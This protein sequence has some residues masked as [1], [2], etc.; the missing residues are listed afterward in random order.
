MSL[1]HA[2]YGKSIV[3]VFRIVRSEA[4][5]RAHDIVEYDV[6]VH[7]EGDLDTSYTQ[8]DNSIVVTTD[9]V[10]NI[11]YHL[12]KISPHILNP[13]RFGLQIGSFFLT[14]YSHIHL[15]HIVIERL[16]WSRIVFDVD[17]KPTP[18]KHSFLRDGE[19]K[20]ITTVDVSRTKTAASYSATVKS[21]LKDLL[22][23]KSTGSSFSNYIYDEY[24]LLKPVTERV[25]ST[26]VEVEYTYPVVEITDKFGSTPEEGVGKDGVWLSE[27]T[28]KAVRDI[29][30][31]VFA[32]DDSASVQATLYKMATRVVA[33]NPPV[34][35][36]SYA[37]PNK[38]YIPVD[39]SYLGIDNLTPE[40]AEVF[41]PV[42]APS[43]FISAT[44]AR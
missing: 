43:G 4:D 39:L 32:T 8:A 42:S 14:K 22:V 34:Q 6:A 2:R 26:S 13:E 31:E 30:L 16:K 41:A 23:L 1:V 21:S 36:I 37:L 7:L 19:E 20:T 27:A 29:T 40:K 28:T 44:I 11:T 9:A 17:G 10:K 35:T 12:A 15:V 24:T 38:H 33:E 5:P 25:F 3:R 18:H